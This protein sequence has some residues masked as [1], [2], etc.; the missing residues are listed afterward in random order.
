MQ[1]VQ[2]FQFHVCH[3][4]RIGTRGRVAIEA[5]LGQASG[6]VPEGVLGSATVDGSV[7]EH[8]QVQAA[9]QRRTESTAN[10]KLQRNTHVAVILQGEIIFLK[11]IEINFVLL[12]VHMLHLIVNMPLTNCAFVFRHIWYLLIL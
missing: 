12:E 8:D 5:E 6:Q 4:K 1:G 7:E 3:H 2:E 10:S 9:R 11:T